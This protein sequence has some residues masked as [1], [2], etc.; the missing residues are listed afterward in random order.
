MGSAE[1][2]Y[3]AMHRHGVSRRGFLSAV[4]ASVAF[5]GLTSCRKPKTKILPF[6]KRPE[7]IEPG[8]PAGYATT[9]VRDGYGVETVE[10]VNDIW[11]Q[12][13]HEK[14]LG[15]TK[16]KTVEHLLLLSRSF[17]DRCVHLVMITEG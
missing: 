3:E 15:A 2:F 1:T 12:R 7:G 16:T 17:Y 10:P 6:N 11:H 13:P 8:V 14:R 5:A 4:A 9:V